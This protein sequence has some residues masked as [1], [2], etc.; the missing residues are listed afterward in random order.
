[1]DVLLRYYLLGFDIRVGYPALE[2]MAECGHLVWSY[3][4]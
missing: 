2:Q 1:M 4:G 3:P